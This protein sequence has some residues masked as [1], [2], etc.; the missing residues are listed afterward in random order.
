MYVGRKEKW[1]LELPWLCVCV[2]G[3]GGLSVE[4]LAVSEKINRDMS[5][6]A[7]VNNIHAN[8]EMNKFVKIF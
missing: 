2:C 7:I 8:C 1:P 3:G 4:V 6:C 5:Y